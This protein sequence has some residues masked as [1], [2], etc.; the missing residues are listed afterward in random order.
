MNDKNIKLAKEIITEEVEKA[1]YNLDKIILFGSR[2]R[3]DYNEDSDYDFFIII[4]E[5]NISKNDMKIMLRHINRRIANNNIS[6]DV[7]IKSTYKYNNQKKDIG[8]LSYYVNTD[9]I[10]I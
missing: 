9:G 2:A 6:G 10:K 1:K 7:I 3:G 8:F 4:K 5:Q